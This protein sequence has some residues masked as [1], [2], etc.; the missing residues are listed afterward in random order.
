MQD[1]LQNQKRDSP[2]QRGAEEVNTSL[3]PA[4]WA[5]HQRARRRGEEG[6]V[7]CEKEGGYYVYVEDVDCS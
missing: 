3:F 7:F 1:S 2:G 5:D 6:S 4:W